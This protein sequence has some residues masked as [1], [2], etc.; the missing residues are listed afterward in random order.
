MNIFHICTYIFVFSLLFSSRI[1]WSEF[2]SS[3]PSSQIF[4]QGSKIQAMSWQ[5]PCMIIKQLCAVNPAQVALRLNFVIPSFIHS[6]LQLI[7]MGLYHGPS[8]ALGTVNTAVKKT[9]KSPSSWNLYSSKGGRCSY[10]V[11]QSQMP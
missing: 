2:P 3:D 10:N 11:R 8:S 6:C 9:T 4:Y 5:I 7:S 1:P